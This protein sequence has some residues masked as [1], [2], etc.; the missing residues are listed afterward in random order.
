VGEPFF[1][2]LADATDDQWVP[3]VALSTGWLILAIL[4]SRRFLKAT[5]R[6]LATVALVLLVVVALTSSLFT[7]I[8]AWVSSHYVEAVVLNPTVQVRDFPDGNARVAFEIH[9]GLKVRITGDNSQFIRVRLANNLEGWVD[10]SAVAK[11]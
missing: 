7:G 1:K 10:R 3:T 9:G 4:L 6:P 2:R 11:L 8:D 5:P